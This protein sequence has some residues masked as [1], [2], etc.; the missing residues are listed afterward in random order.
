MYVMLTEFIKQRS[1]T[2]VSN[3]LFIVLM[4]FFVS[5][6]KDSPSPPYKTI[7]QQSLDGGTVRKW[8]LFRINLHYYYSFNTQKIQYNEATDWED[9]YLSFYA[10]RTIDLG[11]SLSAM[12]KLPVTVSYTP[13]KQKDFGVFFINDDKEKDW[14]IESYYPGSGQDKELLTLYTHFV[15]YGWEEHPLYGKV[16][17]I[18]R[19]FLVLRPA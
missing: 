17:K 7:N 10:N 15:N 13:Q 2:V 16:E 11:D 4:L 3:F 1:R 12:L 5:C 9:Q 19:C 6:K 18:F 14:Q 8:K